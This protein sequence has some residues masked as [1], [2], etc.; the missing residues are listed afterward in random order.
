MVQILS[1]PLVI[2]A[3]AAVVVAALIFWLVFDIRKKWTNIF[4]KSAPV[5]G[6]LLQELIDR[7]RKSESRLDEISPRVELL[8]QISKI[9]VQKVGF[10]RF[11]PFRDIGSDQSFSI[12]LLDG[13]NNGIIVSS[14]Y[15]REGVRVYAKEVRDGKAKQSISEEEQKV[16]KSA[17]EK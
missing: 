16:L 3:A 14:L 8:E 11:N 5:E 17:I 13:E 15:T 6:K 10:L 12:A 1:Q 2:F 7:I 4:G 9:S